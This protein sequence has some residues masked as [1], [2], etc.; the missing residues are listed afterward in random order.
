MIVRCSF[1]IR[2]TKWNKRLNMYMYNSGFIWPMI[3]MCTF[4]TLGSAS[5]EIQPNPEQREL[6]DFDL[7]P[8]TGKFI[9]SYTDSL[10]HL[11]DSLTHSCVGLTHSFVS[12]HFLGG[13]RKNVLWLGFYG[14]LLALWGQWIVTYLKWIGTV[15]TRG[16]I[17][18]IKE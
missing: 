9:T 15:P 11:S 7:R 13:T 12:F 6:A 8:W 2:V 10:I 17:A 18:R 5:D 14:S 16:R 1:F 4:C 3:T